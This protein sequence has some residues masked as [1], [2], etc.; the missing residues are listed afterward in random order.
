MLKERKREEKASKQERKKKK[1]KREKAVGPRE[2]RAP[3][4]GRDL[5][6][7]SPCSGGCGRFQVR[8][9]SSF[10]PPPLAFSGCM[11]E[12]VLWK[13]RQRK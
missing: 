1:E 6:V 4:A 9:L 7:G 11:S 13:T 5:Q 10:P 2:G 8:I 3:G 12:P